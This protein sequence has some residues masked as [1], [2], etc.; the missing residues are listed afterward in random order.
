MVKLSLDRKFVPL[1]RLCFVIVTFGIFTTDKSNIAQKWYP[2]PIFN[3]TNVKI[4]L[5]ILS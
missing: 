3:I 4:K 5:V 1:D 2:K